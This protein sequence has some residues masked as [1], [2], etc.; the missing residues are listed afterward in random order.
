MRHEAGLEALLN[1]VQKVGIPP[2]MM[3]RETMTCAIAFRKAWRFACIYGPRRVFFKALGRLRSSMFPLLSFGK[4]NATKDVAM[5]GCGQFAFATI[6]FFIN[7]C[8]GKRFRTC[9]DVSEDAAQSFAA[10]FGLDE[11]STSASDAMIDSRIRYVYIASNHAS[12]APYAIEALHAGKT[13]YIEKP[14]AVTPKQLAELSRA[15]RVTQRP[16][17]AGYNRPHSMAIKYLRGWCDEPETPLT[18]SCFISGHQ[19]G[20]EHWYR[21]PEEGTRI[22][23]NVGHWLDL[24]VHLL[25]WGKLPD[26]WRIILAWSDDNVRDDDLAISLC[27]S[28]GDLVN[29][30]LTARSEPF[31][32]INETINIQWGKTIAKIDDFRRMTVWKGCKLK[33]YRFWPKDVGHKAAILQPFS[34]SKREW[35][36][37]EL[38]TLLMLRIAEMVVLK[39]KESE[40]SFKN[41]WAKAGLDDEIFYQ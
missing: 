11:I 6:G 10:F 21:R 3:E 5:I 29:I 13:V 35:H 16:I 23:G 12:H 27:S 36:E 41:E 25:Y 32:G 15:V 38:S 37:V 19:L 26:R 9:F 22:C 24:M 34:N 2:A 20:G 7:S 33:Q 14:I 4:G 1:K 17:Y 8:C 31:E 39:E 40:F 30:V 18:M 28:R